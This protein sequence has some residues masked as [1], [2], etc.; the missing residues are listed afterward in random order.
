MDIEE[1]YLLLMADI[2]G[3]RLILG[4]IYGPNE[5]SRDFFVKLER[6]ILNLGNFPVII[7]VDWNCTVSRDHIVDNVDCL[8]MQNLP[9]SRH[10][11]Y[12]YD[13][14]NALSLMDP[15]RGL[16]PHRRDYTYIN[17]AAG[18]S[19]RSRIDFF[20]VSRLLLPCITEC[21]IMPALQSRLFDH[22]AVCMSLYPK[23][24]VKTNKVC[25][26]Q[27]ILSDDNIR[28]VVETAIFECYFHHIDINVERNFNKVQALLDVGK[29]WSS[30]RLA[31][32]ATNI[33]Y[34]DRFHNR[35]VYL[36]DIRILLNKYVLA[37][38]QRKVLSV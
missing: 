4:S 33:Y 15:Y 35:Q 27:S 11:G 7:G 29:I 34:E 1:N 10:S 14:C 2:K 26:S 21:D 18:R 16:F 38:I 12:L 30:L 9:N 25:I 28:I 13:M 20:L 5:T 3:T 31:G 8:N 22:K 23:L 6:D 24:K 32:P 36:D 19:N 17:K 37:D